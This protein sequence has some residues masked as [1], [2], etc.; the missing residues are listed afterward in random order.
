[1]L[2]G[3][4]SLPEREEWD[5]WIEADGPD[6]E[7]A[8]RLR[9]LRGI[10]QAGGAVLTVTADVADEESL[11][12]A[13][14]A[15]RDRFGEVHGVIHAAGVT[16]SFCPVRE[17]SEAAASLHFR[18]KAYGCLAL[19]GALRG[20]KPD[21]VLLLSS[22]SAV[23]GGL[24]YA[25]HSAAHQFLDAFAHQQTRTGPVPWLSLDLD[26]WRFGQEEHRRR[27][28]AGQAQLALT[29]EEGVEAILR[30]LNQTAAAWM[31]L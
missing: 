17:M 24:G 10:E 19:E 14:A 7:T 11:R 18:P 1:M 8:A 29:P 23:L 21:F 20:Q 28:G 12:A 9:C 6:G 3:R 4:T 5:R 2:A 31:A 15:A 16:R 13:F 26:G 27:T 30:F 25:A 22:L